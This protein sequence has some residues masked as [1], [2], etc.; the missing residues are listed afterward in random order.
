[1]VNVWTC[2]LGA[3]LHFSYVRRGQ[4]GSPAEPW[5]RPRELLFLG[6]VT[7]EGECLLSYGPH[8]AGPWLGVRGKCV[9]GAGDRGTLVSPWSAKAAAQCVDDSSS[10][11]PPTLNFWTSWPLLFCSRS[12]LDLAGVG[13]EDKELCFRRGRGEAGL[14]SAE[15]LSLPLLAAGNGGDGRDGVV[16]VVWETGPWRGVLRL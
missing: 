3:V 4:D 6:P 5:V 9:L 8:R 1:M 14:N 13:W 15:A 16:G 10:G 11:R 12:D 7:Q 2:F